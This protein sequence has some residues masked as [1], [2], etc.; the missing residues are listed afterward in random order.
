VKEKLEILR[1]SSAT[2]REFQDQV[3]KIEQMELCFSKNTTELL[4]LKQ[5]YMRVDEVLLIKVHKLDFEALQNDVKNNYLPKSF[6][7]NFLE[8]H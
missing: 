2:R 5:F 8:E 6:L 7:S 4:K 3:L 1:T